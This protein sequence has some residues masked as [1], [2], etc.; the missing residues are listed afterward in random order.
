MVLQTA[1]ITQ[2]TDDNVSPWYVIDTSN[3]EVLG[4]LPS[5]LS[6]ISAMTILKF[7]RKYEKQAYDDAKKATEQQLK[8]RYESVIDSLQSLVVTLKK[9]NE[10]LSEALHNSLD[11]SEWLI[12][13]RICYGTTTIDYTS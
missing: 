8:R 2:Y 7:A 6:E 13:I 12:F 5:E 9:E 4:E 10:E 3:N 1:Q 11:F